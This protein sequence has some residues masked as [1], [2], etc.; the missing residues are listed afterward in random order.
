MQNA[1]N[2]NH[3]DLNKSFQVTK[4]IVVSKILFSFVLIIIGWFWAAY[5]DNS[6]KS[7]AVSLIWATIILLTIASFILRRVLFTT[8]RL[9]K[10]SKKKELFQG[11]QINF[12]FLNLIGVIVAMFGFI[13][14]SLSG[15]K[16]EIVR[17]GIISLIIFFTNFPRKEV[18]AGIVQKFEEVKD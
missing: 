14:A 18:W 2:V 12:V 15:N 9:N 11:L 1:A 3:F 16:F 17:A 8:E 7:G 13:V 5:R 10:L 4:I 6:V